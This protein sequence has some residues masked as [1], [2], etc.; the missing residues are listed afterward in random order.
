MYMLVVRRVESKLYVRVEEDEC[1]TVLEV[2]D[3]FFFCCSVGCYEIEGCGPVGDAG[4]GMAS[5]CCGGD[6]D[7]GRDGDKGAVEEHLEEFVV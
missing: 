6:A 2:C 1:G 3:G 4:G 7:E 5:W